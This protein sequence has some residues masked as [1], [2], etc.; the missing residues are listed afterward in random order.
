[1]DS[2]SI[3][4]IYDS[5]KKIIPL[6]DRMQNRATRRE[7][8]SIQGNRTSSH[9]EMKAT[10]DLSTLFEAP[11]F[12][13]NNPS[14]ILS[15]DLLSPLSS[16]PGNFS[17][18]RGV[19]A[20]SSGGKQTAAVGEAIEK[21]ANNSVKA[22]K[23]NDSGNNACSLRQGNAIITPTSSEDSPSSN[24]VRKQATSNRGDTKMELDENSLAF[25]DFV[26]ME[27]DELLDIDIIGELQKIQD[28]ENRKATQCKLS[29]STSLVDTPPTSSTRDSPRS[30]DRGQVSIN[31]LD[32]KIK[33][34]TAICTNRQDTISCSSTLVKPISAP[35]PNKLQTEARSK[36]SSSVP[37]KDTAKTLTTCNNC[38]TSKTPLWRK[39]PNGNILCNACGLFLK[40]HGTMRPL[41]LKT[42]VI[43]KRNSKRQS[44]S[45]QGDKYKNIS[46]YACTPAAPKNNSPNSYIHYSQSFPNNPSNAF[47]SATS[48]SSPFNHALL[49]KHSSSTSISS[50]SQPQQQQQLQQSASSPLSQSLSQRSKNVPI[51]PKPISPSPQV[52]TQSLGF[53][54]GSFPSQPQDI[55]QFKRRKSKLN[56]SSQPSSPMTSYSPSAQSPMSSLRNSSV[57]SASGMYQDIHSKRGASY[58]HINTDI[59]L[60]H[61]PVQQSLGKPSNFSNLSAAIRT[62][63]SSLNK[64]ATSISSAGTPTGATT[65]PSLTNNTRKQPPATA[66]TISTAAVTDNCTVKHNAVTEEMGDV[67]MKDLDWLKFDI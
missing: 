20:V 24:L 41:S 19:S 2:P 61:S 64:V 15:V 33:P 23:Y 45:A 49:S 67:S 12:M 59:G 26:G 11:G 44:L 7:S 8:L 52:Q 48:A 36:I 51:L 21:S 58:N 1:M 6:Y 28:E 34:N 17:L 29:P 47:I 66:P 3:W 54:A 62:N 39:D 18:P 46:P 63:K 57:S 37:A 60:S 42:D 5:A 53:T 14:D 55:P 32:I 27:Y 16:S 10:D 40:L 4:E 50:L 13:Y 43:K 25:T 31:P 65:G 38:G 30:L 35:Q 56:L 22:D 9:T